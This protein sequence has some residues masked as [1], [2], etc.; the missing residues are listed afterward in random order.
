MALIKCD[1][2]NNEI[3]DQSKT[4]P[5]C[6]AR[7][8]AS[9][10]KKQ[11]I[12]GLIIKLAFFIAVIAIIIGM[13]YSIL[14]NRPSYQYAKKMIEVFNNYKENYILEK[15]M[16]SELDEIY[17]SLELE[18]KKID[19]TDNIDESTRLLRL[20]ITITSIDIKKLSSGVKLSDINEAIEDVKEVMAF[21]S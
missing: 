19:N 16:L 17:D 13:G 8:L 7:T 6:G 12:N 18:M 2:C 4:C 10:L 21:F 14:I 5:K 1:E 11:K 3:S 9:K 15:E 20:Q